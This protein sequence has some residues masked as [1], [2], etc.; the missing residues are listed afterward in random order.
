M[1]KL[2]YEHVFASAG[3]SG[4]TWDISKGHDLSFTSAALAVD[5]IALNKRVTLSSGTFPAWFV[6]GK[7]FTTNSVTNPGPFIVKEVTSTTEIRVHET[8]ANE[9]AVTA[10]FDGSPDVDIQNIL[11]KT[12][13]GALTEDAPHVLI[14]TGALGGARSLSISAMEVESVAKGSYPLNGRF[15]YLSV[16]NSD[17]LTNDLTI[18]SS[19]TINGAASFIISTVGD[20]L[21]HH[22]KNGI[23]RVNLLPTPADSTATIA[24]IPFLASDWD[25]GATK[26]TI[27]I[28]QIGSPAAGEVG[29]HG[30]TTYG[31][32]VVQVIN[33]DQ[34][35]DEM[36]DVEIQ[37]AANGDVT[38]KKAG[39]LDFAGVA[40]IVGS[41]D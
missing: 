19:A 10:I 31:S 3:F 11:L 30:L 16:Q 34:T 32:Y 5:F 23:W 22:T 40:V 18:T 39:G 2:N 28:L 14:S 29:P 15:F 37:F 35:P 20:Y 12:G 6:I 4:E 1:A 9:A 25:A 26:N 17:I 8:V 13:A 24:R 7:R 36:V 41:L 21:F 38:L 33:T 27:K